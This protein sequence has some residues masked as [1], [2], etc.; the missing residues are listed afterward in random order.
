MYKKSLA[1]L[2]TRQNLST[3]IK[4]TIRRNVF[5]RIQFSLLQKNVVMFHIGRSGS[6]V[7]GNLLH[8][9]PDMYWDGEI[10][11][12]LLQRWEQ[13]NNTTLTRTNN[14]I[15][16]PVNRL[17][18]RMRLSNS[19][20]YGFEVKFFHLN[21]TQYNLDNYIDELYKLG[22][23]R[24]IILRRKNLLRKIVSSV[25][26]HKQS[27]FHKSSGEKS[28]LNQVELDVNNIQIDRDAKPLVAYLQEFEEKFYKLDQLLNNN[29]V[30]KL[31]YEDDVAT[32]PLVGYRKVCDFLE[33]KQHPATVQF[34]KTNPFKLSNI[35]I[36][37][38]DVE[39][40]LGETPF[41]WMLYE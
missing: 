38:D 33:I 2:S 40:I 27:K 1:Q 28:K 13:Q 35:V 12:G 19:K 14:F 22:V 18:N 4:K 29:K 21:F 24:F 9:H 32:S 15:F 31:T 23:K 34:S 8:Q 39:Q 30:L 10:Y 5:D 17:R 36:N 16:N 20:I 26:A 11:E 6:S 3:K 7:L 25:V 37:F 41:N